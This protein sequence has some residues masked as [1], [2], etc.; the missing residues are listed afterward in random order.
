MALSTRIV[1]RRH[2]LSHQIEEEH[3][4]A[5]PAEAAE[6]I[7]NIIDGMEGDVVDDPESNFQGHR[8]RNGWNS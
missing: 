2:G 6:L 5:S 8:I 7:R 4:T 1:E 3:L